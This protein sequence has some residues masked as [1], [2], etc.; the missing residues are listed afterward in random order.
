MN[1]LEEKSYDRE[2]KIE[3]WY[4]MRTNVRRLEIFWVMV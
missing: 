4:K 3:K 2:I 1:F